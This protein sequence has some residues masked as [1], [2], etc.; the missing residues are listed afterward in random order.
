[1]PPVDT[2][3][4]VPPLR[5]VPA[6]RTLPRL[7]R[8]PLRAF[9]RIGRDCDGALARLHLGLVRPYLATHPDHVQHILR[10]PDTY[11]REG[12]MW[13]PL[14]RLEGDGIAGEGRSWR[15][16][17]RILQPLFTTRHL[18]TVLPPMAAAVQEALD[19]LGYRARDRHPVD[20]VTEMTGLMHRV[21][22]R[23]F[24]GDRI[25]VTDAD[26]LGAAIAT[27]FQSLGWRMLLPFVSDAVPLPGDRAFR[28]AVRTVDELVYPLV[29]NSRDGEGDL[30]G[31]LARAVDEHGAP[32]P[33]K[34]VRDDVV[35]MFVAGT[36]TTALALTWLWLLLD[37]HPAAAARLADEVGSMVGDG[38]PD[39]G[40]LPRL[41]YTRAAL[42]ETLRLYPIGWVVP[43]TVSAPDEIDGVPLRPGATVLLS[44][45][46]THRLVAFWDDPD[47]FWPDRFA[48]DGERR[49][50][51][52][53]LPFGAGVH[54]CL[55]SQFFLAEAQL[56]VAG[57]VS[58]FRLEVTG[59]AGSAPSLAPRATASLRPRVRP[60][61]VLH[62]R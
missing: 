8:D 18:S 58:R 62:P 19:L 7:A 30:V 2:P 10:R 59:P 16:S 28:R 44:P 48:G 1:M 20:L 15:A 23:V 35:A 46:L 51:F 57:L 52:A 17:R 61:L 12:M 27:A 13:K 26:R 14:R 24:F 21:M 3:A 34:R 39:P 25:R 37:A 49:H 42:Q 36:E 4:P 11:V 33:E 6:Y 54:Q 22:V 56:A 47:R 29:R 60:Q 9:A 45:Y 38:P 31:W 5:T 41:S 40:H 50:R 53:Y 43:R 55:G 32:L